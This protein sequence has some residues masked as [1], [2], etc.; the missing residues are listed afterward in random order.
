MGE[1]A[2]E[3]RARSTPELLTRGAGGADAGAPRSA[4]ID[5]RP[6]AGDALLAAG[7]VHAASKPRLNAPPGDAEREPGVPEREAD[8]GPGVAASESTKLTRGAPPER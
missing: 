1:A 6:R 7:A 5:M 2:S 3:R 4:G 8:D